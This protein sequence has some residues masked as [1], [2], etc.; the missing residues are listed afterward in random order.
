MP[1]GDLLRRRP[2]DSPPCPAC[3]AGV[4]SGS[5]FCPNCGIRLDDPDSLPLHV[6]DRTTKLFNERFIRPILEDELA[7]GHRYGRWLGILLVELRTQNDYG[8]GN[9]DGLKT[10]AASLI[11]SLRDVDTPGLLKRMPAQFVVLLP[12]A[13]MSGTAY[14]ANRL[15]EAINTS[16]KTVDLKVAVG[17]VC[18]NPAKRFRAGGVIEAA[19]RSLRTGRPE[20]LGR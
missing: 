1:L 20:V 2:G 13:E 9:P 5:T 6:V 8:S 17:L 10:M 18:V 19:A 16:L 15:L 4:P 3:G 7:R 14:T 11:G 12:E